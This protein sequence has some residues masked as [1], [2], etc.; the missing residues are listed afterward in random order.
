MSLAQHTDAQ[1]RFRQQE[2]NSGAYVLPFIQAA[3]PLEPGMR[4]MEIGCGEGGVL[5]P[6]LEHGCTAVGV[7]LEPERI[8]LA[9]GF[10]KD[11]V[12]Q[13]KLR[14]IAQ[15]IYDLDFLG[16]FRQYFDLIILKDA[17]E[18]IPDQDRLMGYLQQLLRPGGAIFLGFPPWYMPHGGHQ[19]ICRSKWLSVWPY[20]HLLPGGWYRRLLQAFGEDP[21]TV[22]E[23]LEIKETGI[24]IERFEKILKHHQYRILRRR[25][26][27]VNPIYRYKFGWKP[28][29]QSSMIARIPFWRNFVTTCMYYLITP[30]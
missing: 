25:F 4:V 7:D 30:A 15:N 19:Q 20:I 29:Q 27:L 5:A 6:F 23:L 28:R 21:S 11:A 1:L 3:F 26:Y 14:L 16:E 22:K 10:L 18:H 12:E 17:I 8:A 2:E 9:A 13:G 24:S